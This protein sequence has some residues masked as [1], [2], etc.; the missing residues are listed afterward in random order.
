[1]KRN[2]YTNRVSS[3]LHAGL[4]FSKSCLWSVVC[5]LVDWHGCDAPRV[6]KWPNRSRHVVDPTRRSDSREEQGEVRRFSMSY[7]IRIIFASK[8]LVSY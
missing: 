7:G 8:L 5:L 2:Y 3:K 4:L 6:P 1:M